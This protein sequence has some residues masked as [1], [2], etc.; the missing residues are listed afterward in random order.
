M[1][2]IERAI[3]LISRAYPPRAAF[4]PKRESFIELRRAAASEFVDDLSRTSDIRGA[5]ILDLGSGSGGFSVALAE[6]GA[7]FV[8]AADFTLTPMRAGSIYVR[9]RRL[10][11]HFVSQNAAC[12]GLA[13]NCF[14]TILTVA[15]FEHFPDPQAVLR[16]CYRVLKPGGMLYAAFEPYYGPFGG[17]LF[18]FIPIPW[19]HLWCPEGPLMRS[20]ITLASQNPDLAAYNF[21][22][23]VQDGRTTRQLLNRMSVRRFERLVSQSRFEVIRF[24]VRYVKDLQRLPWLTGRWF[25]LREPMTTRITAKL[26]KPRREQ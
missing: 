17:H 25:P 9:E 13:S 24:D 23:V 6:R 8:C 20:W 14:D 1:A 15:T 18:D 7:R 21:T 19:I 26:R 4:D 5:R 16:E 12:L 2:I 22:V 11:V 3:E 10:P